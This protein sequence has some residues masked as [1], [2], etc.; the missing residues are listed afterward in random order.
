MDGWIENCLPLTWNAELAL[1]GATD[2]GVFVA[3]AVPFEQVLSGQWNPRINSSYY[4]K[5]LELAKLCLRRQRSLYLLAGIDPELWGAWSWSVL[6]AAK[7]SYSWA[8]SAIAKQLVNVQSST[9][10]TV[11]ASSLLFHS[12]CSG[13]W[14]WWAGMHMMMMRWLC[15]RVARRWEHTLLV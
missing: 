3:P 7:S 15:E 9:G 6:S 10:L 1:L 13:C 4:P 14:C 5:K 12:I 8:A 11:T 2:F